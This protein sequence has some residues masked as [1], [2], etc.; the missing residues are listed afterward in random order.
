[1]KL[2]ILQSNY[3]KTTLSPHLRRLESESIFIMREVAAEFARPVMLYSIGKDSSVMLHLAQKAFFPGKPP[4]PVLHIDT[5]HNFEE[6]LLFRDELVKTTG[7]Q[8]IVRKVGDT[9][10]AKNL[11]DTT[12]K[13]PSR[14]VLQ[15]HTLLDTISEFGF[16]ACIG[17]GRRDE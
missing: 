16:E 1:M 6:A 13:F 10:K 3:V 4:F 12:G 17:G 15:S 14:N 5:G 2:A 7:L 9:I 11:T 8:L